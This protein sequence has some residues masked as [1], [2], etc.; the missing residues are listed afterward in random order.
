[1]NSFNVYGQTEQVVGGNTPVW[2]GTVKPIPVGAIFDGISSTESY[3]AGTPVVYDPIT[4]M[5][6]GTAENG[7]FSNVNAYLY[8]DIN[9]GAVDFSQ[10]LVATCAIVMNHPEGL[11]I[12]RVYPEITEEQIATL[13]KNIPGVLLVRG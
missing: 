3:K 7:D 4:K 6:D 5:I 10:G 9:V 2:L 13:Q 12:E 8:N 1:M 11:L